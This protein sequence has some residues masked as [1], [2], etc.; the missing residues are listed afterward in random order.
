ME[1]IIA[2]DSGKYETKVCMKRSDGTE[3]TLSFRSKVDVMDPGSSF[4]MDPRESHVVTL[5]GDRYIVGEAASFSDVKETTKATI[6]HRVCVHA[7]IAMMV[8]NGDVVH[9][10]IGCPLSIYCVRDKVQAYRDYVLPKGE[11][12]TVE[13]DGVKKTFS[14][15]TVQVM[16]E[17]AGVIMMDP[18]RYGDGIYGVIDIGGLN[19]NCAIYRNTYP[20]LRSMIT[21]NYG[22]NDLKITIRKKLQT[23]LD[24]DLM[25]EIL[26]KDIIRGYDEADRE[27]SAE[28]ITACK[29]TQV[30]KILGAC[31][32]VGWNVKSM[33]IVFTGGSAYL[34]R[35]EI[36]AKVPSVRAEDIKEDVKYTNV[37]GFL[38]A[39]TGGAG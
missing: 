18:E 11:Q 21:N 24:T 4:L 38:A 37:R 9:A 17:G 3:K 36:A 35:N 30:D 23:L 39:V 28:I 31:L 2:V 1:R 16:P 7:A 5:D 22:G 33:P 25:D 19:T 10:V 27:G 15:K 8:D 6:F 34:L 12:V 29:A 14:I 13:L 32:E 20:V 26:E